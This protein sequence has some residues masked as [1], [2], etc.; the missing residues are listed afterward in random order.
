VF[1]PGSSIRQNG[2]M[3]TVER[4][5]SAGVPLTWERTVQAGRPHY[6]LVER[7]CSGKLPACHPDPKEFYVIG[8]RI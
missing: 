4:L 3:T 8:S 1:F 7:Y 2:L 6:K 5:C